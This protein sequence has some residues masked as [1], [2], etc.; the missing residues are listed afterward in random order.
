MR[1]FTPAQFTHAQFFRIVGLDKLSYQW[2][3]MDDCWS[4][5]SR[6]ANGSLQPDPSRFPSGMASLASYVHSKGLKIGVYTCVGTETCRRGRPGSYGHYQQDADTL[7]SWGIDFV[8]ADNCARP[9]NI[10]DQQLYT[11]FSQALNKTGRP[12]L[13]SLCQWGTDD[14]L[15]WGAEVGQMFR[16]QMDHLPVWTTY[17]WFKAAGEGIG[18][19]A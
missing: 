1:K 4:S 5:T 12:I 18:Q 15:Q 8:K 16:V 10:S 2:I 7:A 3:N 19:G 9:A 17:P 14:V 11:D 6:T 13:F